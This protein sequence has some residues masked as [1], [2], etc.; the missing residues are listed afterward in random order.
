MAPH[1][2]PQHLDMQSQHRAGALNV[3]DQP[4]KIRRLHVGDA[5]PARC[6]VAD[7]CR[8]FGISRRC[9]YL[10]LRARKFDRFEILPPI[11]KRAWSG[12]KVQ[13]YLGNVERRS[14]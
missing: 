7:M 10:W 13:A 14:A 2:L 11:G 5:L 1:P 9:F 3:P 4:T 6:G 12:A 8:A